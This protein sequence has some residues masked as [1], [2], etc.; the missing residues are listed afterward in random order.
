MIRRTV[1]APNEIMKPMADADPAEDE[2][3]QGEEACL[4]PIPHG[5]EADHLHRREPADAG[6]G[7]QEEHQTPGAR[8]RRPGG[9]AGPPVM[10]GVSRRPAHSV[11]APS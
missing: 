10:T 1:G 2:R 8:L 3:E 9:H 6:E 11:Q 7:Q 4:T 5:G